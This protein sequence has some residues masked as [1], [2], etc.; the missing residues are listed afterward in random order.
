MWWPR[1]RLS[2]TG[3]LRYNP[4]SDA[5]NTSPA[6]VCTSQLLALSPFPGRSEYTLHEST[7]D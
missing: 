2:V 7:L 1:L 6:R 5:V 3:R 4:I